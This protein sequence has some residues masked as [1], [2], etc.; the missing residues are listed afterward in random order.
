MSLAGQEE[1]LA[2]RLPNGQELHHSKG[3][4]PA[5]ALYAGQGC[6]D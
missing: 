2:H 4:N 6:T 5:A 1:P 3:R